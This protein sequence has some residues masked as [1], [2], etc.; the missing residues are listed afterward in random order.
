MHRK[1]AHNGHNGVF[2]GVKV[3][4]CSVVLTQGP[5]Q[6]QKVQCWI[7]GQ[8]NSEK[9][10]LKPGGQAGHGGFLP[11]LSLQALPKDVA[12]SWSSYS[13]VNPNC[14]KSHPASGQR[15]GKGPL[16]ARQGGQ[17]QRRA[18]VADTA[19]F[20][21]QTC[22]SPQLSGGAHTWEGLKATEQSLKSRAEIRTTGHR[23]RN[24]TCG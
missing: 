20:C 23:W 18:D 9:V 12:P 2:P 11:L 3:P 17:P 21:V 8:R 22:P 6:A 1:A 13:T 4:L 19:C 10:L 7:S 15:Q 14:R 5:L 16:Q 24:R